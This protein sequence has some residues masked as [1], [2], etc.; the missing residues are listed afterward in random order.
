MGKQ[1]LRLGDWQQQAAPREGAS[2]KHIYEKITWE[3]IER[4]LGE[5]AEQPDI[6]NDM[7]SLMEEVDGILAENNIENMFA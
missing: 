3:D 7:S 1:A 2:L 6:S 4:V 5:E